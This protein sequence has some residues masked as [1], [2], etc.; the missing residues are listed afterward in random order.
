MVLIRM[1]CQPVLG[2]IPV[3]AVQ[4]ALA[5]Q[6]SGIL[7]RINVTARGKGSGDAWGISVRDQLGGNPE[8]TRLDL[9]S[10]EEKRKTRPTG[11]P[12]L[13]TT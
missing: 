3:V 5:G 4:H 7:D 11:R 8:A 2:A 12:E 6:M 9:L 13:Y 1:V 10:Q